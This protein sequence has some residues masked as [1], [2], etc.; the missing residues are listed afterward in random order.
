MYVILI[1]LLGTLSLFIRL[2][3]FWK[4]CSDE[5][6]NWCVAR[7]CANLKNE[8][9]KMEGPTH[10]KST[11]AHLKIY[12]YVIVL[13]YERFHKNQFFSLFSLGNVII[14]SKN[15]LCT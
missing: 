8:G 6:N 1:T 13:K 4:M 15:G 14:D 9:E 5:F 2:A 10:K 7:L 12:Y 11:P 3:E